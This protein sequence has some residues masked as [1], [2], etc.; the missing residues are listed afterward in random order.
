MVLETL[1]AMG[2]FPI[3]ANQEQNR[4]TPLDCK[5]ILPT[6]PHTAVTCNGGK[7]M[8]SWFDF[9]RWKFYLSFSAEPIIE[10]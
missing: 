6:A 10:K 5:I 9:H 1:S 2:F 8:N 3:F 4:L 7:E